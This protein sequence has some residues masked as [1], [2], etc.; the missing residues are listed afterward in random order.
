MSDG[1]ETR[2][3]EHKAAIVW[4][5]VFKFSVLH[6]L[7]INALLLFQTVALETVIFSVFL[8]IVGCVVSERNLLQFPLFDKFTTVL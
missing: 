1:R 3:E 7:G 5:N 2:E 8:W 4:P 6:L